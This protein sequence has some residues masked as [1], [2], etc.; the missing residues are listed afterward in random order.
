MK[1]CRILTAAFAASLLFLN[2][3]C[4][5]APE[6]G[7]IGKAELLRLM[8][9]AR[10]GEAGKPPK[11]IA[12]SW[13][14]ADSQVFL[15]AEGDRYRMNTLDRDIII[16]DGK[17]LFYNGRE[18]SAERQADGAFAFRILFP[19]KPLAELLGGDEW[20]LVSGFGE[21]SGREYY[22]LTRQQDFLRL[23]VD[24]ETLLIDF[25]D[26]NSR[27]MLLVGAYRWVGDRVQLPFFLIADREQAP[28]LTVTGIVLDPEFPGWYFDPAAELPKADATVEK[29]EALREKNLPGKKL[30]PGMLLAKINR[31]GTFEREERRYNAVKYTFAND[32]LDF[33][34]GLIPLATSP[35][36]QI[37]ERLELVNDLRCVKLAY[38][39]Q[40]TVYLHPETGAVSRIEGGPNARTDFHYR[41]SNGKLYPRLVIDTVEKRLNIYQLSWIPEAK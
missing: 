39:G 35:A 40:E 6:E 32:W 37:A 7:G 27:D 22:R 31:D 41:Q 24:P 38:P 21:R 26:L 16:G 12:V 8:D 30:G 15:K 1:F 10:F 11:A 17:R 9:Q 25:I 18:L 23:W 19:V 13:A 28:P 5:S 33:S 2:F 34:F 29:L 3:S 4:A 36:P 14:V 20:Q